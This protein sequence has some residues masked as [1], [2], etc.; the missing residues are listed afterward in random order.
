MKPLA[1]ILAFLPLIAFSLLSRV[2]PHGDIG[3][4]GLVAAVIALIAIATSRP[5][6]PPKIINSCSLVLFTLIAVL[7]FTLGKNDDRWLATWGGSGIGLVIGLIMYRRVSCRSSQQIVPLVIPT[8]A[9]LTMTGEALR[10]RSGVSACL[11]GS[12]PYRFNELHRNI[13]GISQRMLTRTLRALEQDGIVQRSVFP[14]VPVSVEYSV[15]DLGRSLLVPLSAV[16]DWAVD[17]HAEIAAAR[18]SAPGR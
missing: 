8:P 3:I 1:L 2:L 11:L 14:T 12:R 15:T 16:A 17:H 18:Q 10:A 6:W 5:W 4:A 9:M 13:Q 7:G